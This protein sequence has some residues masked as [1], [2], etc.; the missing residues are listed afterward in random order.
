MKACPSPM[1]NKVTQLGSHQ[2]N[3]YYKIKLGGVG[4]EVRDSDLVISV[5]VV[6]KREPNHV[7]KL[8]MKSI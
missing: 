3:N 8:A 5:V 2:L 1:S 7:Y 6:D 4:Y